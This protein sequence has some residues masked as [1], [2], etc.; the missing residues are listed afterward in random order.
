M[1]TSLAV[2]GLAALASA[3]PQGVTQSIAPS[4]PAPAG[5]ATSVPQS[6]QITTINATTSPH[7]K[8]KR[9]NDG[10]LI[11]TL[12]NGQLHN[13]QG[14]TGYIASNFQFQ[15]DKPPQ[16]GAIYTAGFSVCSN[17]SLAL[18]GSAIFYSC[19]S[20]GFNNLYDRNWAPQ[21]SPIYINTI[22]SGSS[23]GSSGSASAGASQTADGQPQAATSAGVSQTSDHQPQAATTAGVTQISD[24][25]PQAAT[26]AA[27]T[28]IS[29]HQPQAATSAATSAVSQ[30][31]DH[32]PQAAT[33]AAPAVT[34]ISDH[35]PQA[36]TS[37]VS[38]ISD[39][40]PQAGTAAGTPAGTPAA[41]A[42]T[43][44]YTGAAAQNGMSNFALAGA[45]VL[46]AALL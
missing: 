8:A 16:T 18:G 21:C 9:Q 4:A 25:Q 24:H 22:N 1:Y 33:T 36:A 43:A 20:G 38:Q 39:H 40:Q 10:S 27:V 12:Q 3:V 11:I 37:A 28:Q 5:C 2:L 6:F 46:G 23:S 41:A 44:A 15:F 45:A 32:Q 31:S 17:G 35:Q 13:Q 42:A 26:S 19:N 30:I 29:D 7:T 14:D 34:Q